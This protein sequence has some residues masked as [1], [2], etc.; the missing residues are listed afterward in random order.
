MNSDI[1]IILLPSTAIR[2]TI[3]MG[4]VRVVAVKCIGELGMQN[5]GKIIAGR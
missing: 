4:A 2:I 3:G 5:M 1:L